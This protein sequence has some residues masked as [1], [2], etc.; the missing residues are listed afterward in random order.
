MV[1][2]LIEERGVEVNQRA[3]SNG[4]TPL[5]RAARVA[6]YNTAPHLEVF[7]YLLQVRYC[8]ST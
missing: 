4:W 3:I 2:F 8:M 7:E 6:H 5:H 1:K